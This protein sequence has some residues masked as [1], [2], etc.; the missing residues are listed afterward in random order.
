LTPILIASS[1]LHLGFPSDLFPHGFDTTTIYTFS[2]STSL[3]QNITH[4][5]TKSFLPWIIKQPQNNNKQP[6]W[7]Q[8]SFIIMMKCRRCNTPSHNSSQWPNNI[9]N[10]N[11]YDT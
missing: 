9:C 3:T 11:T 10:N 2:S 7:F 4:K 6:A 8:V 1:V 5:S